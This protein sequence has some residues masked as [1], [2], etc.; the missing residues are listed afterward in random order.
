MMVP[1][2]LRKFFIE[3]IVVAVIVGWAV[4][5]FPDVMT[6]LVPWLC[7][8]LFW[9]FALEVL[10]R[11]RTRDFFS[12]LRG[13]RFVLG[14]LAGFIAIVLLSFLVVWCARAATRKLETAESAKEGRSVSPPVPPNEESKPQPKLNPQTP[15]KPHLPPRSDSPK[16]TVTFR[17]TGPIGLDKDGVATLPIW[18]VATGKGTLHFLTLSH[19]FAVHPAP[20]TPQAIL[21]GEDSFWA[22]FDASEKSYRPTI[23]SSTMANRPF[24]INLSLGQDITNHL[25]DL[26]QN[27]GVIYVAIRFRDPDGKLVE[28]TCLGIDPTTN[29]AHLCS[30]HNVP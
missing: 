2:G 5:K 1:M 18:F 22:D 17:G 4:T 3:L 26:R 20:S 13:K 28:Q 30:K 14:V 21:Q 15:S 27:G 16:T 10:T 29:F 12:R 11:K 9:H 25:P 24:A 8:I 6:P 23:T 7:L 19:S